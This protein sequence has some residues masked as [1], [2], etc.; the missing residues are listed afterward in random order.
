[1]A[2]A[3][4]CVEQLAIVSRVDY[5]RGGLEAMHRPDRPRDRAILWLLRVAWRTAMMRD[6]RAASIRDVHC[7]PVGPG[8]I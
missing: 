7:D 6:R 3:A 1:M 2:T 4:R 8:L 5:V